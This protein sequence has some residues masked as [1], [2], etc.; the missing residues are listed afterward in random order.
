MVTRKRVKTSNKLS[1]YLIPGFMNFS[2]D[3]IQGRDGSVSLIRLIDSVTARALPVRFLSF[4]LVTE[5]KRNIELPYE[6]SIRFE[7]RLRNQRGEVFKL[8][9]VD[10]ELDGNTDRSSHRFIMQIANTFE[11]S[12]IGAYCFQLIAIGGDEEMVVCERI[13]P[14]FAAP[15]FESRAR[16]R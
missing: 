6:H 2:H 14:V 7:V 1:D 8:A 3:V 5:F 12:R 10:A 15:E 16:K 9:D 11:L 4:A 13:L